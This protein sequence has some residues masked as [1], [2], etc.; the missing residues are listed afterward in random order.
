M[1]K[2]I[3]LFERSCSCINFGN[4]CMCVHLSVCLL[5]VKINTLFIILSEGAFAFVGCS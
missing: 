4:L 3:S 2:I 1:M 5:M